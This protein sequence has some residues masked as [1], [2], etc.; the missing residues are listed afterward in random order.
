MNQKV[1]IIVPCY[2]GE[3]FVDRS[4]GSIYEQDYPNIEVIVVDDGSTDNSREAISRWEERYSNKGFT[5]KYFFQKNQ[6]LGGAIN[7]GLK[8]VSGEYICLLDI[9]DEYLQ[10]A[11]SERV[12][13]LQEN[14][15]IYVVRSNGWIVKDDQKYLFI[16]EQKEKE[17]EDVFLALIRGETNNWAGS[18][19]VRADALF[20]FYPNR[21]IY[22]SRYGQ[23][24]QFLLPL[25]YQRKCGYIDKPH[26]N[27][28]RQEVSLSR[29]IDSNI[30]EQK[31]LE[32]AEGYREIRI[33]MVNLIVQEEKKRREYRKQ[34]DG[35]YWR[36]IMSL[37]LVNKNKALM[38]KAYRKMQ[39]FEQPSID[40]RI[41]YY[42]LFS[43]GI[44][45]FLKLF[46]KIKKN[47]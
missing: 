38:K 18:Y 34:I 45:F 3:K 12:E 2:N 29:T 37:S 14:R 11:I 43:Q 32:N 40:D 10:G 5:L 17:I 23:N 31:S 46:R 26:M 4:L 30:A 35:A 8:L 7:A 13:F 21:E 9:D 27:Y 20:H 41:M 42:S 39:N 6:G 33:H 47:I 19:M 1:S 28:I 16:Y 25:L 44:V 24:L 36:S 22:Q 15:D